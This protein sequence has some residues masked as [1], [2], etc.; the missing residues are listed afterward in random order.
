MS[1][2]YVLFFHEWESTEVL[3]CFSTYEAAKELKDYLVACP[4]S[5]DD[6][7]YVMSELGYFASEKPDE[8]KQ[9]LV[10]T[11]FEMDSPTKDVKIDNLKFLE[12]K[13]AQRNIQG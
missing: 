7:N 8:Y 3:G 9:R 4:P 12:W 5:E 6:E 13:D 11:D 1:K 10:I 2:F